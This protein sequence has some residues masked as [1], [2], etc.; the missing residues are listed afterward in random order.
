MRQANNFFLRLQPK[1]LLILH[2]FIINNEFNFR[3]NFKTD[4]LNSKVPFGMT[5]YL[6]WECRPLAAEL[7]LLEV[8]KFHWRQ[9]DGT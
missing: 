6:G 9:V 4:S 8:T 7:E 3:I 2:K 5:L 1:G